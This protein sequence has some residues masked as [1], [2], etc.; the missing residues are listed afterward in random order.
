LPLAKQNGKPQI[1]RLYNTRHHGSVDLI[2]VEV[3]F[4]HNLFAFTFVSAV[5]NRKIQCNCTQLIRYAI[6]PD[7]LEK[8]EFTRLI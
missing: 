7:R 4:F 8:S 5:K 6:K 1:F 3:V 2:K